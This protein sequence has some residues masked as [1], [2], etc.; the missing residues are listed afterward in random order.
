[1]SKMISVR[2]LVAVVAGVVVGMF[3]LTGTAAAP[4]AGAPVRIVDADD[5]SFAAHVDADGNLQV[6]G[7]VGIDPAGNTVSVDSSTPLSVSTIDD[8]ARQAFEEAGTVGFATS[9]ATLEFT[10][11]EGKRLVIEFA[12]FSVDIPTGQQVL[13]FRIQ[14]RRVGHLLVPSSTGAFFGS[15]HFVA[16]QDLRLYADGGTTVQLV[17]R[18]GTNTG[19]GVMYAAVS[20]YLIDCTA[21]PCN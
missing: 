11:P 8:A 21:A 13:E 1:M 4:P 17:G 9:V 12:S 3:A 18:R 20:G 14:T 5:A 2:S 6:S 16:S 10:V 15:D 19:A 7:E